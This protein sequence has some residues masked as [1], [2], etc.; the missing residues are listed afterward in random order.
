MGATVHF[1]GQTVIVTGGASGIGRASAIRFAER[2]ATVVVADRDQS[3]A[4]HTVAELATAGSA[5]VV[6]V[7][8]AEQV[9]AMVA[10]AAQ[11]HG[12]IDVLVNSAGFGAL[13]P[14][15]LPTKTTGT[16]SWQS[17]SKGPS[18]ARNMH[19]PN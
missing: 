19:S 12:R 5:A 7:R 18:S 14:S 8:N 3:A 17:T 13:A 10:R 1:D 6:D 2:G 15:P 4:E 9:A 11:R 16:I